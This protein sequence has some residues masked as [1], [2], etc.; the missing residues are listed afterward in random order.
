VPKLTNKSEPL[1]VVI[2][3]ASSG[4]GRGVTE[5]LA[6]SGANVVLVARRTD[7]IEE[8]ASR[9]GN[10]I[11][12][13]ADVGSADDLARVKDA[14][15]ERFGGID[16]WINNAGVGAAGNFTD[17]PLEDHAKT[18]ETTLVGVVNGSHIALAHFEQEGR[19]ILINVASSGGK[20]PFP[21]YASYV[22]AKF[23]VVGLGEVLREELVARKLKRIRVCTVNPWV[24]DTPWF[25]HAANYTGR[26]L[27]MPLPN[28]TRKVVKAVVKMVRHPKWS[29]DV[30]QGKGSGLSSRLMPHRTERLTAK[31]IKKYLDS[32]PVAAPPTPG[33][34]HTPMHGGRGLDGDMRKRVKAENKAR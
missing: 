18:I 11:A 12:V 27:R 8:I 25:E 19:G 13:T 29:V 9:L 24:T 31:M 2:T 28:D 33:A 4:I 21:F 32:S 3:G 22:A 1:T 34:L 14:A 6:K 23:G 5:K 16:V 30:G 15:I 26:T 10:A 7:L 17:I 20:T